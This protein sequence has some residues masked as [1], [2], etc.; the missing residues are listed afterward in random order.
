MGNGASRIFLLYRT[1]NFWSPRAVITFAICV[2][3]LVDLV[4][5][6][7]LNSYLACK[8]VHTQSVSSVC[9]RACRACVSCVCWCVCVL[10]VCVLCVCVRVS[11]KQNAKRARNSY[12]PPAILHPTSRHLRVTFHAELKSV[13]SLEPQVSKLARFESKIRHLLKNLFTTP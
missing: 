4:L 1:S 5:I 6:K 7:F 8:Q 13:T 12:L 3:L 9:V 2:S 10:C 11:E